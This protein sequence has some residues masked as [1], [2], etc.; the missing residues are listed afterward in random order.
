MCSVGSTW[1]LLG[2]EMGRALHCFVEVPCAPTYEK[3]TV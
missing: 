1:H 2:G 3:D